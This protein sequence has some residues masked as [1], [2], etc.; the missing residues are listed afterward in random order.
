MSRLIYFSDALL[1]SGFKDTQQQISTTN[2]LLEYMGLMKVTL[3]YI[4]NYFDLHC[5][6]TFLNYSKSIKKII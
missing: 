1:A 5:L 3:E 4:S 6:L 2:S